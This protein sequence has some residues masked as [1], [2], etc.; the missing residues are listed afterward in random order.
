M[1]I[2]ILEGL[3]PEQ[4]EAVTHQRAPL[5]IIAGAGTGKTTVITRRIAWLV[6]EGLAKTDEILALTFT[7][8]A[9]QEMQERVDILVPYG[10]TDIW[11]STFHA[12]GDRILRE[13]ALEIGLSPDFDVLTRPESAVFFRE[14]LFK[15]PISYYRP[16][17]EPTRFI[18][19]MID[20]FS[21]A[22]DEDTSPLEYLEY[23]R[24]LKEKSLVS[25][26]DEALKEEVIRE[27]E[28][29]QCYEKYIELLMQENKVD[30]ANQFYLALQLFRNHPL[31]LKKYQ[32]KFKYILV[33]EFQDTNFA[34][35]QLVKLLSAKFRDITV[36]GDDDQCI[37]R[38]RGA[39]YSNLLRFIEDFPDAKKISIIR[40]FR[41]HQINLD[42]AYRLIQHNNPERFETKAGINKRLLGISSEGKPPEHLHFDTV[43]NEADNVARIIREKIESKGY[44]YNDFAI[45]VRSNSDALPFIRSL[46]M[47]SVPWRFTGNQGLY[48]TEEIR[49]VISFLRLLFNLSDSLSLYYLATHQI[50]SVPIA[51]LSKCMS[52]CRKA[53]CD[54]FSVFKNIDSLF[55]EGISLEAREIIK[56]ITKDIEKF[57][58]ASLKLPTGNLLYRFLTE[59]GYLKSLT[60]HPS[61]ENEVKI[62]NLAKFFEIVSDFSSLAKEDR[63]VK[64]IQ[65]LD[66]LIS[67]GDD[68]ATAEA[69]LDT[70]SVNIMTIHK[71]K[72]LE[73]RVVFLVSLVLGKFPW[74]HRHQPIELPEALIKD[75]LPT[76]DFHLQE[77]R[78]LFYV[79]MTR[80]KE[81][82]YLTSS[83][84]YGGGR[85]RRVSQFVYEAMGRPQEEKVLKVKSEEL[86]E[87]K[88]LVS[89]R[90]VVSPVIISEDKI[91]SLSYYSVDDYLSCPLKYKYVHI[92]RIPVIQHHTVI[93]GKALHDTILRYYEYKIKG[94]RVTLED[95][96]KV[97]ESSLEVAGFLTYEHRKERTEK[98][99]KA[100]ERFYNQEEEKAQIPTYIEK[101]FS[102]MLDN[103]RI[104]GRW[105]RIDIRDEEVYIIDFKSSEI[106]KKKEAD[107]KTR[108]SLQ[109]CIYSLAYK[110][111][112]GKIPDYVQ[113]YFLESGL[114]GET[115]LDNEDL[116]ET[117][118]K[119]RE[120]SFGIRK[121]DFSA[122]PKFMACNY[123]AYQSICPECSPFKMR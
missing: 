62:K 43:S 60:A 32:E 63:L 51:E 46:N 16:L 8:K 38:W 123:C 29:A 94:L 40:N 7:D 25:P 23:A 39:A 44:N 80:A 35:Y 83:Q 104:T 95:L 114:I 90:P 106:T 71:A 79:G 87:Q 76:G 28:I 9:A 24:K 121:Q 85:K 72:G 56:K 68:P 11:I 98:G 89:E 42:H 84:D 41:S 14:H 53:N 34:Q 69:D 52:Y 58:E 70:P 59:T 48:H 86:I 116:E 119:I 77:E 45:L 26:E 4:R 92:L 13:H 36:T 108:E 118:E 61:L 65:Y 99:R 97:F 73:F 27:L 110:M 10:Y 17:A 88:A 30:F 57:L 111:L 67:C 47:Y 100:L 50:Y 49:L 20:L 81:E 93:Y 75:I 18:E 112:Y 37:Y 105:D 19:A 6:S 107:K 15:F 3:N 115:K 54:L 22:R 91:L 2:D 74:P 103:I 96:I 120:V 101:D 64:F 82:L 109:L 117:I 21:R 33:D 55:P 12:F 122:R 66:L 102:V 31:I 113:L 5:L 1:Q 78:R